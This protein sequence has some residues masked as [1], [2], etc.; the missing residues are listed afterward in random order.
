VAEH[1]I[2]ATDSGEVALLCE[3]G[4]GEHVLRVH[5]DGLEAASPELSALLRGAVEGGQRERSAQLRLA[6]ARELL[7]LQGGQ[8]TLEPLAEGTGAAIVVRLP[9][10]VPDTPATLATRRSS[11]PREVVE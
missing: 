5:G 11:A 3:R 10:E 2:E 1:A 8:I 6:I 9:D 7:L 4:H